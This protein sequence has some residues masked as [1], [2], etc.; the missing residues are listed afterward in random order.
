VS[1]LVLGSSGLVGRRLV[2]QLVSEGNRVVACDVAPPRTRIDDPQLTYAAADVTR[3]DDIAGLIDDHTISDIALLSY[4]MGPLMNPQ[5]SDIL[6]TCAVN[7]TGVTNVLE[8][9]RLGGVRRVVFLSTV[10]TYGPQSMYGERPVRED[11]LLAPGSMYGKMEA[12]N[13][14]IC[15]RYAALY[16]LEVVKVR[17]SSILGP[18][19]TIW[20]SRLIERVAVGEVGLVPYGPQ[21]RDNI[22]AVDDLVVLLSRLLNAATTEH[23]T[24]L[25]AGHNV[26]MDDLTSVILDLLP[27]AVLEYPTP[28]RRPTY[29]EI[30]DNSRAAAEFGWTLMSVADSVRAHIDGVRVEAGLPPLATP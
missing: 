29:P 24:Y 26:T 30:F 2:R 22:V 28:D 3:L 19:S 13:E 8:A 12:L 20:P 14:S 16:D 18:G 10:G 17:P 15:D 25:A 27:Q 21:A 23:N 1:V 11:E 6:N 5:L 9:A 7:I 4:V